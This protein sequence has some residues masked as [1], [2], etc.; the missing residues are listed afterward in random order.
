MSETQAEIQPEAL[1]SACSACK[2]LGSRAGTWL[3]GDRKDWHV[4]PASPCVT[5]PHTLLLLFAFPS[6]TPQETF[7]QAQLPVPA[8]IPIHLN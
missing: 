7:A 1:Q 2:T 5:H 4:S 3:R 8:A 6:G